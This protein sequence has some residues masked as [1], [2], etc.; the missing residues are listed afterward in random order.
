MTQVAPAEDKHVP[1]DVSRASD[2]EKM[3]E[4][5]CTLSSPSALDQFDDPDEGL[6]D[7]ERAKRVSL[8]NPTD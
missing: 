1:D 2:P 6:S 7:E 8:S 3:V 4:P 5:G